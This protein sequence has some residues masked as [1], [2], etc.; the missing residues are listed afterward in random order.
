M[1]R[2]LGF[3]LLL[4]LAGQAQAVLLSTSST[5]TLDGQT[6]ASR[7]VFDYDPA[8][9][10]ATRFWRGV[11]TET[12][13]V[14]ALAIEPGGRF[15]LF[16][17]TT[18]ARLAGG[19]AFRDGDLVRL[20]RLTG[21]AALFLSEDRFGGADEDLDAVELLPSGNLLLSTTSSAILGGLAFR[22]GDVIEY[23]PAADAAVR[24][25]SADV[26]DGSENVDA[27]A[28]LDGDL[29]L[30]TA[31]DAAI[32]GTVYRDGDLIRYNLQTGAHARFLSEAIFGGADE[33][34][35]AVAFLIP[36]PGAFA[37]VLAGLFG[38]ALCRSRPGR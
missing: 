10:A 38:I 27:I 7:D 24:V 22:G 12:E 35:D 36:A 11:F 20:D 13:N 8:T 1:T 21:D 30:S 3:L 29:I 6:F 34:L 5:A 9:G 33:D 25:F 31:T 14:D 4:A 32:G 19:L 17:T 18:D 28:L 15:L 37:L 2:P 16:S 26:F 23:D